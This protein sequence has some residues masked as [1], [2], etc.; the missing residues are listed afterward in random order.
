MAGVGCCDKKGKSAVV[1][2]VELGKESL[3]TY[4]YFSVRMLTLSQKPWRRR[5]FEPSVRLRLL[6]VLIAQSKAPFGPKMK[7][8]QA[9]RVRRG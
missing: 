1:W 8:A 5:P 3:V 7:D 9:E 2:N 6:N 4:M